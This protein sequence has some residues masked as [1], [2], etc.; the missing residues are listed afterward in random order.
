MPLMYDRYS[1]EVTKTTRW[2]RLRW[3]ILK[4]DN[5]TCQ[6]CGKMGDR[7]DVDHIV[8]VRDAPEKS[9]DP[10]NLQSLCRECHSAKTRREAN[11]PAPNPRREA[12]SKLLRDMQGKPIEHKG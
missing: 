1:R 7:L 2:R 4:R 9:F 12:W 11:L 6:D 3:Q 8:P 5:F 10:A